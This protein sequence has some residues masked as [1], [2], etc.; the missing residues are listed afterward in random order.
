MI[1]NEEIEWMTKNGQSVRNMMAAHNQNTTE[2]VYV[3]DN[4]RAVVRAGKCIEIT[5]ADAPTTRD[6][7]EF[8]PQVGWRAGQ[9]RNFG[10]VKVE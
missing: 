9:L 5:G 4:M 8:E 3:K 6:N 1:S 10:F 7:Y 2:T